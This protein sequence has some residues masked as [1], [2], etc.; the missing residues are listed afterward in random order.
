MRP[1]SG[2]LIARVHYMPLPVRDKAG[3][4]WIAERFALGSS[5]VR[6]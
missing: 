1:F 2:A 4:E 6:L 3:G 5:F